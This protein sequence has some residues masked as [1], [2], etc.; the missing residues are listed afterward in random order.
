MH[1][2]G[3]LQLA[4]LDCDYYYK[5]TLLPIIIGFLSDLIYGEVAPLQ[6]LIKESS[7]NLNI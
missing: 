5:S 6:T 3:V 1:I 7:D 2:L 4:A